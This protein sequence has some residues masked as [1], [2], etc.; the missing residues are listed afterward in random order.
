MQ[1]VCCSDIFTKICFHVRTV[2]IQMPQ[3]QI[4]FR[5]FKLQRL[6]VLYHVDCH[7]SH[8]LAVRPDCA[9]VEAGVCLQ[10]HTLVLPDSPH[11]PGEVGAHRV[12]EVVVVFGKSDGVLNLFTWPLNAIILICISGQ[13]E[14]SWT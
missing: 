2:L 10:P 4:R 1:S 5:D 9:E 12:Q 14:Y 6:P 3:C 11:V 13:D 8:S 7:L